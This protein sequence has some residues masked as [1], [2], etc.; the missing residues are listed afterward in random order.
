MIEC[1]CM[2]IFREIELA[3]AEPGRSKRARLDDAYRKFSAAMAKLRQRQVKAFERLAD[4]IAAKKAEK[5]RREL[6]DL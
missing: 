2:D 3:T 1:R 6:K 5:V 4:K